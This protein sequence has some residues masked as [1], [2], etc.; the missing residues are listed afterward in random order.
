MKTQLPRIIGALAVVAAACIYALTFVLHEGEGALTVRLGNPV[1]VLAAP[2][3]AGLHFSWPWPIEK[4]YRYDLRE[5]IHR[6]GLEE[7]TTADEQL[8]VAGGF[9]LWRVNDPRKF[10]EA[11]AGKESAADAL[12]DGMLRHGV[13]EV[14]ARQPY[15]SLARARSPVAGGGGAG[16]LREIEEEIAR[17]AGAPLAAFGIEV[18]DAGFHQLV[19]PEKAAEGVFAQMRQAKDADAAQVQSEGD[20]QARKLKA[21]AQR[22]YERILADGRTK[23]GEITAKARAEAAGVLAAVEDKDLVMF[24]DRLTALEELFTG[25]TT[26]VWNLDTP[27]LDL[28]KEL[29]RKEPR[30]ADAREEPK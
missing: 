9:V 5:R 4:V 7:V 1:R 2:A 11:V 22:E 15:A 30:G 24:L 16:K 8:L 25:T 12:I 19:L 13:K 3:D 18:D 6:G 21:E 14:L 20:V 28:L 29:I 27:P 10:H 26:I 17:V 23:A